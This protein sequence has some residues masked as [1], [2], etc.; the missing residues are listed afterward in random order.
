MP[1]QMEVSIPTSCAEAKRIFGLTS[2]ITVASGATIVMAA[3]RSGRLAP[4]HVMLLTRAGM[5]TV[6]RD[7]ACLRIGAA[8][9]LADLIDMPE[10]LAG[11][12]L[13]VADPE[14]RAQATIGG[15]VCASAD[16]GVPL[17]DLQGPLIAL[18]ANVRW[19]DGTEERVD[20]IEEFLGGVKDRRLVLGLEMSVPDRGAFVALRR[21]HSHGY[22]PLAVSAAVIGNEVRLAATGLGPHGVRL[23][24]AEDPTPVGASRLE[25]PDDALASAWY[26]REMIP[27]LVRRCLAQLEGGAMAG[28]R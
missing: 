4:K 25:P 16:G 11:A 22:T 14:I 9:R 2:E 1:T 6:E 26:R 23:H 10:P 15:N 12:V 17:G 20:G 8:A 21:P 13:G 3:M 7:G 19:T 27:V 24:S 5:D 28:E 18:D